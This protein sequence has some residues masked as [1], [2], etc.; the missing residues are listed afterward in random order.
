MM[1]ITREQHAVVE[2]MAEKHGSASHGQPNKDGVIV[3]TGISEGVRQEI[4]RV[5]PDGMR[6]PAAHL[7]NR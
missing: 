2:M 5:D 1:E 4:L 7:M 6:V 3:V